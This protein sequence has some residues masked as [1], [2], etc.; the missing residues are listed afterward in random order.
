VRPC[1]TSK[2]CLWLGPGQYRGGCRPH[3]TANANCFADSS[4]DRYS[5]RGDDA[6]TESY[7]DDYA[8]AHT[9][10]FSH[11]Y[12]YDTTITDAY[13]E[14]AWITY[15]YSNGYGHCDSAAQGNAEAASDSASSAVSSHSQ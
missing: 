5:V 15:A 11:A 8:Y 4:V 6:D 9:D 14:F 1:N 10:T 13:A 3:A 2:Q 7:G 12:C